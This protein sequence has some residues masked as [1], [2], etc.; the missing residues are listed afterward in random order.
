MQSAYGTIFTAQ[1]QRP[2]E[3]GVGQDK[4]GQQSAATKLANAGP[5]TKMLRIGTQ[6]IAADIF[7]Q[8]TKQRIASERREKM[9]FWLKPATAAEIRRRAQQTGLSASATG[10]YFLEQMVLQDLQIQHGALLQ[11]MVEQAISRKLNSIVTFLVTLLIPIYVNTGQSR[12]LQT[13][14]IA[15]LPDTRIMNEQILDHILDE[16]AEAAQ[17]DLKR[18]SPH[19]AS[20]IAEELDQLLKIKD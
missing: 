10:A 4:A 16:S 7:C 19:L 18:R 11:P 6:R 20:I 12:R 5:E 2:S 14:I 13:N 17:K 15:R 9:G 1:E 3:D 8:H